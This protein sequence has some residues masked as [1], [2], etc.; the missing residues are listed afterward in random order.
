MRDNY[1]TIIHVPQNYSIC[2]ECL[3]AFIQFCFH[4]CMAKYF[5][6]RHIIVSIPFPVTVSE[7][8]F[9]QFLK[10]S[11][12]ENL[13]K[14]K[15]ILKNCQ[16]LSSVPLQRN[17]VPD[18]LYYVWGLAVLY[19]YS[20]LCTYICMT[21]ISFDTFLLEQKFSTTEYSF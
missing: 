12:V 15:I 4:T 8:V 2:L 9:N 10:Y 6:T 20:T 13:L 18:F 17:C 16:L 7:A 19:T 3:K 11:G 21:S 14:A 1:Y 5:D